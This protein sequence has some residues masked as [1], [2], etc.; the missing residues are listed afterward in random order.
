MATD[1]DLRRLWPPPRRNPNILD[2]LVR[3]RVEIVL[4]I[5]AVTAWHY[6]GGRTIAIA[7][8]ISLASVI[9][10]HPVR[11]LAVRCWELLIS[12]HRVRAGLV[13]AGVADR[14][15]ALPWVLWAVP[16]GRAVRVDLILR[17]GTTVEDV[18]RAT[19]VIAGACGAA[20]IEVA[21]RPGRPDRVSVILLRP[22][23]GFA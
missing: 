17:A 2:F 8:A 15:G 1:D 16:I 4:G 3:W 23:W 6:L 9:A 19:P 12:P 20:D 22:R 14:R 18:F 11:Q 13:Q 21:Q 5:L 7:G 10:L